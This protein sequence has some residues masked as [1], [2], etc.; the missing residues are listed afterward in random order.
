MWFEPGFSVR[1][2]DS[3]VL[4]PNPKGSRK[5]Y[6]CKDLGKKGARRRKVAVE[7]RAYRDMMLNLSS[8]YLWRA[9]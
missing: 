1:F 5:A 2:P 7:M 9:S 8:G 3:K 4:V 6:R